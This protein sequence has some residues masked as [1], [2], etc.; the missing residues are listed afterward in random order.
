[1]EQEETCK[2]ELADE[3]ELLLEP[4]TCLA[5]KLVAARIPLLERPVA[6]VGELDDRRLRAVGEVRIPVSQLLRQVE[7]Q[8]LCQLDGA[9]ECGTVVGKSLDHLLR[10]KED[11]FVVAAPLRFTAVERA[12]VANGHEHVLKGRTAR[13]VGVHVAG[14]DRRDAERR[15]E[16]AQECVSP[17]VAALVGTLELDVEAV[18]SECT[19]EPCRRV[20]VAHCHA[21]ACAAG[22]TDEPLVQLFEQVLVERWIGRTVA[23]PFQPD[24]CVRAP[25]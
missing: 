15:S 13:M 3:L 5:A 16:V 12:A 1:M 21:V 20:R 11:A 4:R 17:C 7:L 2:P 24:A 10:R 22:K 14:G 23:I 9:L 8:P 25:R 19:G 6:D 18:A